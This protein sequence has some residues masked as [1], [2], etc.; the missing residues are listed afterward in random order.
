MLASFDNSGSAPRSWMF[1]ATLQ[2]NNG[3]RRLHMNW[4]NSWS[5]LKH[6]PS[7]Q[8]SPVCQNILKH[9]YCYQ[10]VFK[11]ET[12]WSR[13]TSKAKTCSRNSRNFA[14]IQLPGPPRLC[15]PC[16]P[17]AYGVLLVGRIV[18]LE[19]AGYGLKRS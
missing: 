11:Q 2:S 1:D 5:S 19:F 17:C 6:P 15:T 7:K 16:H 8:I 10:K 3:L 9:V 18:R 4:R 12:S 14:N 13:M